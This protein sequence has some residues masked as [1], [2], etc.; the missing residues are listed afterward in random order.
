MSCTFLAA[1]TPQR[2]VFVAR[3]R[4]LLCVIACHIINSIL[5]NM[6]RSTLTLHLALVRSSSLFWIPNDHITGPPEEMIVSNSG[7]LATASVPD[8][9]LSASQGRTSR[10]QQDTFSQV[11]LS[12][13]EADGPSSVGSPRTRMICN[14]F[15][16]CQPKVGARTKKERKKKRKRNKR[17]LQ[18][19]AYI[20]MRKSLHEIR[21]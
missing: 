14:Q 1:F 18:I 2:L 6:I 5:K 13:T 21:K 16:T 11:E 17:R 19:K 4:L 7:L 9:H 15:V 12:Q 20:L 8:P 10:Q 3:R